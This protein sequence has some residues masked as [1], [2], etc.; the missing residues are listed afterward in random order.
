MPKPHKLL[1]LCLALLVGSMMI[2]GPAPGRATAGVSPDAKIVVHLVPV[3][4][5]VK[6]MNICGRHG[7]E[8][9]SDVVT[10]GE[11][12]QGYLAYVLVTDF[13]TETGIAGAQFGISYNDS[14]EVGVDIIYWQNCTLYEWPMDGWPGSETGNLLTWN[15]MSDC[16]GT[17]P[18]V[19]GLFHLTA[20]SQD[21]FKIIPRPVDGLARLAAC[22][23][24][25]INSNDK[26]DT[27]KPENL[28]WVDFGSGDGYNPWDPEQNLI[29]L[30]NKF[31]PIRN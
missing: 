25:S 7:V 31:K 17:E 29:E 23:V 19:I 10:R 16:Q 1:S 3:E 6:R 13:D 18:L 15:Q 20:H 2:A 4:K 21:R 26:L 12:G 14:A 22:G 30:R 5:R 24:N 27:L 8:G 28:G 11:T 9:L